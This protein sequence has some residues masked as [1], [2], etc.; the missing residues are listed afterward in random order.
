MKLIS[1]NVNGIRAS[2]DKGLLEFLKKEKPDIYC[3]QETKAHPEQLDEDL[4]K[5]LNLGGPL[6]FSSAYKKGY[7]GVLTAF[8]KKL[9]SLR[10]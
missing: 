6:H 3:L 5:E 1:W 4:L 2:A 8:S 9:L 7:S 10:V